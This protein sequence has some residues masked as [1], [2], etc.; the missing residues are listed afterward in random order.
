[1]GIAD[2]PA[3]VHVAHDM[4]DGIKGNFRIGR[5]MHRQYDAGDNLD[6]QKQAGQGTEVPHIVQIARS[7]ITGTNAVIDETRQRKLLVHPLT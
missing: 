2:H 1:M 3:T 7:R 4:F 5:I 6:D